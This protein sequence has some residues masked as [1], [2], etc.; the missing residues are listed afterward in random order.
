MGGARSRDLNPC[1]WGSIAK[2]AAS[3]VPVPN[4]GA[5]AGKMKEEAISGFGIFHEPVQPIENGFPG[6]PAIGQYPD[7][8]YGKAEILQLAP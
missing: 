7:L 3:R 5:M 1:S 4:L 6:R 8:F 2:A